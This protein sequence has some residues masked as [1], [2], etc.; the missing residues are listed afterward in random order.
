MTLP[1]NTP[2]ALH[3]LETS[4]SNRLNFEQYITLLQKYLFLLNADIP[5]K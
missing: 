3:Q 2:Y 4:A 1:K 5:L